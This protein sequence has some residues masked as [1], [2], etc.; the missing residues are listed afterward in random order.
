MS[1]NLLWLMAPLPFLMFLAAGVDPDPYVPP[2]PHEPNF[3]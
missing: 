2:K 1:V 3:D